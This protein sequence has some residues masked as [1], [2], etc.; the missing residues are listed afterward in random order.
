[1]VKHDKIAAAVFFLIA[2]LLFAVSLW[3]ELRQPVSDFALFVALSALFALAGIY[4]IASA[5]SRA[6]RLSR[7]LRGASPARRL[8]LPPRFY[9]SASL[10]WQ[11][12]IGGSMSLIAAAVF[13]F[14]AI[15]AFSRGW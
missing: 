1:M 14:A 7:Q 12:R 10:L 2:A 6:E 11:L 3:P 8:W 4:H 15:I 13:A 9:T 5:P